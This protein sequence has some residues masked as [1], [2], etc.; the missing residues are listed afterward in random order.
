VAERTQ[1]GTPTDSNHHLWRN[2]RLWWVAF[3]IHLPG[4]QKERVRLSLQTADLSEA[5]KRRD[6]ILAS[7][8]N[9][10]R[11]AL[12]LRFGTRRMRGTGAAA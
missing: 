8:P 10:R 2:G 1:S 12:S 9:S 11:C 7:Y 5:R 4:W 6:V 3:T